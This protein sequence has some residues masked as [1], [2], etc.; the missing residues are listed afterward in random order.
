MGFQVGEEN[1][2]VVSVKGCSEV[3]QG[4]DIEKARICGEGGVVFD[5]EK[6][7]FNAVL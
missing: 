3:E 7:Y 2:L 5:F 4:E 6:S 1:G